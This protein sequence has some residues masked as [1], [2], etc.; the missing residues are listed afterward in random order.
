MANLLDRVISQLDTL[1][2]YLSLAHREVFDL[3]ESQYDNWC[4]T[5]EQTPLPNTFDAFTVQIAH[6]AFVLGFSY[7]DAFLADLIREIY[8]K[9]PE[10]LPQKKKLSFE[11]IVAASDYDSV[12]S[13]MIDHEVH[14]LMYHGIE[15][16]AEYFDDLFSI[17]WPRSELDDIITA[18]LIRNCIVHNNSV[19]DNRLGERP[20]WKVGDRITLS[21]SQVH[22]FGIT[23]RSLVRQIYAEAETRHLS[24][25]SAR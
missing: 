5:P 21:V 9:H 3:V 8:S 24:R 7:A 15:D 17:S 20:R 18:S 6:S 13:R 12:I 25:A 22:G 11:A 23:A 10:M 14:D 19:A 4:Q 1:V 16:V 2:P